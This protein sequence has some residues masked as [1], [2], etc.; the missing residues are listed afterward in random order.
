MKHIMRTALSI[1]LSTAM[2]T[3]GMAA[4][5]FTG[6]GEITSIRRDTIGNGL[7]FSEYNSADQQTYMFEY[8]PAGGTLPLVRY[9][10]TVYGKD[11]LGSLATT[12]WNENKVVLGAVNGD[13]YSIQTGVPMGIMIDDGALISTDDGK[14]AIGFTAD[15]K[16]VIGKPEVKLTLTNLSRGSDA[17]EID[18]LNKFPTQ[19]GVY[20]LTEEFASTT[21]S[22]SES[23]EIVIRLSGDFKAAGSISGTVVE[24]IDGDCNTAIPEDCAVLTV[25]NTYEDYKNFTG[26]Q[27]G[28]RANTYRISQVRQSTKELARSLQNE[29]FRTNSRSDR[30]DHLPH[31]ASI[32]EKMADPL[33]L[34][35]CQSSLPTEFFSDRRDQRRNDLGGCHRAVLPWNSAYKQKNEICPV[36]DRDLCAS[37]RGRGTTALPHERHAFRLPLVRRASLSWC[38]VV[39]CPH[40][41]EK[42][43]EYAKIRSG[44][45]HYLHRVRRDRAKHADLCA[46]HHHRLS[47]HRAPALSQKGTKRNERSINSNGL[48]L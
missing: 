4:L 20:L 21:L 10:S 28:D 2:L 23:L 35:P 40:H 17:L 29:T 16:A 41:S 45:F 6:I 36:G 32:K 8:D 11:R 44:K 38:V 7:T 3:Q 27:A 31:H 47:R 24:V 37:L 12:L 22:S 48:G 9:G 18:Q 15:G 1:L 13:F 25:A 5:S 30:S 33:L 34:H 26:I 42:R 43:A 19:W 14:Y 39:S 46:A